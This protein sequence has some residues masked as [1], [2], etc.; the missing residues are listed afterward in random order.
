MLRLGLGLLYSEPATGNRKKAELIAQAHPHSADPTARLLISKRCS[1]YTHQNRKKHDSTTYT[2]PY[3][4]DTRT[5][6]LKGA[7][8]E[9][10]T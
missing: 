1:A 8:V 6:A 4:V 2:S 5:D 3:A 9:A 10:L 7:L